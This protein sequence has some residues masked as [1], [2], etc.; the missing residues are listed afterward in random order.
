MKSRLA[1][2]VTVWGWLLFAVWMAYDYTEYGNRWI[3]H[4]FQPSNHYEVQG[5]YVLIFLIPLIYTFLGYLVSE[6]EKLLRKI[7]ESEEKY[8][9]LSLSDELTSLHNRRGFEFLAE[10]QLQIANRAKNHMFLLFADVDNLKLINDKF[11]HQEGDRALIDTA[12]I[13]RKQIRKSDILARISGDEFAALFGTTNNNL[14]EVLAERLK[15][16]I[17]NFNAEETR[18]YKISLSFGFAHYD[19]LSPCSMK[20]LL[21][22]ADKNMYGQKQKK[23]DSYRG[24]GRV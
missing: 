9:T 24:G 22:Y 3:I 16:S 10:Q 20:E 4:I 23:E 19:P 8:R 21:S 2:A 12:D 18:S 14:P 15:E 13:L 11:G 1:I 17:R 5:F 6:R 7:K